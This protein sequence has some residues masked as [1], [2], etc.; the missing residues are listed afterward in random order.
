MKFMPSFPRKFAAT[1]MAFFTLY[2]FSHTT[3]ATEV[4]SNINEP[5]SSGLGY[6]SPVFLGLGFRTGSSEYAFQSISLSLLSG[7]SNASQSVT[8]DVFLYE[9]GA[10]GLP[11]GS[12]LS[13]DT[14]VS[15]TWTSPVGGGQFQQ[16]TF[17]YNEAQLANMFALTLAPD[18]RYSLVVGNNSGTPT[19]E[20]YWSVTTNSYATAD[21]FSFTTMARSTDGGTNWS[22]Q[23]V[24][25]I[26]SI[27]VEAIPEP[28][29]YALLA[30]G[31][32][33]VSLVFWRC[34]AAQ[35]N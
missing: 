6:N 3:F 9:A 5:W 13:Q 33:F 26:A 4:I 17:T 34:R 24:K 14:G 29:T 11:T 20:N 8:F 30:I 23:T 7:N 16:Q 27:S 25:P 2:Q 1:L 10:N 19:F 21:G 12:F 18:T 35:K 32:G 22:T 28:A 15:A 31:L